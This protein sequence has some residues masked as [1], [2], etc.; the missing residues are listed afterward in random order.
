MRMNLKMFDGNYLSHVLLLTTRQK[1]ELRNAFSNIMS[2]D[3]KLSKAQISKIIQSGEFLRLLLSKLAGPLMKVADLLA[4]NI[5]APLGITAAASAI[6]VGIQ[7]KIHSSA[8]P[9]SSASSATTLIISNKEMNYIIKIVQAL[10][11]CIFLFKGVTKTIKKETKEQKGGFL[12]M[13]FGTFV[14]SSFVRKS[15]SRKRNCKSWFW[16]QKRK[17]NCKR[18][19]WKRMGF[20]MPLHPLTN[21]EIKKYYQNES[22]FNGVYSGTNLPKKIKDGAYV[23]NLDE[24]ANVCT[25]WIALFCNISEIVYFDSFGVEHVS[26][27]TKKFVENKNNR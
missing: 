9:S 18:W 11:D 12:S 3:L 20:L 14:R 27:E 15:V 13:L 22:R 6:D 26:E 16:K 19:L 24:Y 17:G 21:F 7:K 25:H 23:I 4:E 2:T 1:T 5:L 8:R 10:E